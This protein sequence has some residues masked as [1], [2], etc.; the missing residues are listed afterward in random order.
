MTLCGY[1]D[2]VSIWQNKNPTA[3]W[4]WGPTNPGNESEPNRHAGKRAKQQ[5]QIQIAIHGDR[6][7]RRRMP[8]N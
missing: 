4:Q 5:V 7:H 1:G 2:G 3:G 6:L 8:V